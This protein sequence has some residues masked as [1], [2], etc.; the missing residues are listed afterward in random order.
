[1]RSTVPVTI[2]P[3]AMRSSG[4]C[5]PAPSPSGAGTS[6]IFFSLRSID[7]MTTSIVSFGFGI[8][9][10]A[11]SSERCKSPSSPGATRTNAP[12]SATRVTVPRATLPAVSTCSTPSHGSFARALSDSVIFVVGSPLRLGSTCRTSRTCTS[13][14]SPTVTALATFTLRSCAIS[15][16]GTSPSTPPPMSTN[17][18]NSRTPV[19]VPRSTAP[20]TTSFM[21]RDAFSRSSCSITAR[22]ESVTLLPPSRT[23]V[24]RN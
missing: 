21:M 16:A 5:A 22:R 24:T 23:S 6:E 15:D 10:F 20:G 7:L 1:M 17:A 19:T 2:A 13:T 8:A 18:P 11:P 9:S 3:T 4:T 12:N 14:T